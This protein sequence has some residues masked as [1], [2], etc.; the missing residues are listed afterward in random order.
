MCVYR[1]KADGLSEEPETV[2]QLD[3]YSSFLDVMDNWIIYMDSNDSEGFIN[4]LNA[5]TK[6][7]I[8][9]Y[10]LDYASLSEQNESNEEI[11]VT[12]P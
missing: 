4:L 2:K 12:T 5:D 7:E 9:V 3:T 8:K 10:S 1:I 11:L 6:E